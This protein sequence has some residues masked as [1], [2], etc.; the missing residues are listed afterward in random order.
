M[1]HE[2]AAL[3]LELGVEAA[4]DAAHVLNRVRLLLELF[5]LLQRGSEDL[6]SARAALLLTIELSCAQ[7]ARVY[8]LGEVA[9]EVRGDA[10]VDSLAYIELMLRVMDNPVL[11][12]RTVLGIVRIS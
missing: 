9:L 11:L 7:A 3:D 4:G 5:V 12:P 8:V 2:S 1:I 10:V 6:L